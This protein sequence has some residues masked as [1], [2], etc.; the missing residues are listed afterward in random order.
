MRCARCGSENQDG[1]LYCSHC[2][3]A[4]AGSPLDDPAVAASPPASA[5]TEGA[6][7]DVAPAQNGD[8]SPPQPSPSGVQV[9]ARGAS[10]DDVR[11]RFQSA[12]DRMQAAAGP[13]EQRLVAIQDALA[14]LDPLGKQLVTWIGCVLIIIGIFLPIKTWSWSIGI[15]SYS[16]TDNYWDLNT[17]LSVLY[18][19]ALLAAAG[20]AYLRAYVWNWFI[21]AFFLV[22]LVLGFINSFSA[23]VSGI[24]GFSARPSW[25]WV[26]LVAGLAALLAGTAMREPG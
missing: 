24:T 26:F 4:L 5:T 25:G 8:S 3:A 21:G 15:L 12:T 19:I 16:Q 20:F 6:P 2:G 18:L 23:D 17:P 22:F 1:A 10:T 14:P 11:A 13:Y 7:S 9:Q